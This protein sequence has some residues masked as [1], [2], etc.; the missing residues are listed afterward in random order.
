MTCDG[1]SF[2]RFTVFTNAAE[3]HS[4]PDLARYTKL[5][6]IVDRTAGR[7]IYLLVPHDTY[8]RRILCIDWTTPQLFTAVISIVMAGALAAA[9][10]SMQ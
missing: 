6:A 7:Y 4:A 9:A 2:D 5:G 3:S 1:A 10:L 8:D